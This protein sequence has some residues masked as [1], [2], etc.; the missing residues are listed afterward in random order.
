MFENLK[1]LYV[2]D[3]PIV[4]FDT[5]EHLEELGFSEV[6]TAFRLE[7]AEQYLEDTTFDLALLDINLDRG[8]TSIALGEKLAAGHTS[9]VFASGNSSAAQEIKQSGFWFIDKPFE[10]HT[11]TETLQE[12]VSS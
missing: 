3:E 2:E 10:L 1:I 4:A 9:V 8:Q 6:K 5:S 7:Q 12:V 11:L